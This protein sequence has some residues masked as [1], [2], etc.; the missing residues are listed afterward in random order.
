[1][2]NT[3]EKPFYHQFEEKPHS[4]STETGTAACRTDIII[5]H[6]D[7]LERSLPK[8]IMVKVYDQ[9]GGV[10]YGEIDENGDSHHIGVKCGLI[11][12]QL[13][14]G[15]DTAPKYDRHKKDGRQLTDKDEQAFF[16]DSD[17]YVL[18]KANDEKT[19]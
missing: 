4:E 7:T 12:W 17:G 2:V 13:M 9:D 10:S 3:N 11:S 14:R 1:M 19:R 18:I 6:K 16:N 5:H 8:G 15:P